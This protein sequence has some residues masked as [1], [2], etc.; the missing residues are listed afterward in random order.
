M[1]NLKF[2][3]LLT[4]LSAFLFSHSEAQLVKTGA[5][6]LF[7]KHL[8]LIKGKRVGLVVN[9]TAVLADGRHL[10]DVVHEQED[11]TLAALFGP[12]HSVRGDTTGAVVDAVDVKTGVPVYSLYGRTYKSKVFHDLLWYPPS[13]LL[14]T[15]VLHPRPE[16]L[17]RIDVLIFDIQDIGARFYTYISTLGYVMEAAA[18]RGI[19]IIVLDRP[20][21]IR[22]VYV[23]G[24]VRDDTLKSNVA[25]APITIGH[26]MTV[27]EIARMYNG[28]RWL[29]GGV[30]ADLTVIEMEGW[31]R[32]MWYD[33]TGLDWIAPSPN[34]L[35][36]ET[37]AV[38][39]GMCLFEGAN[40][41]EGRGTDK[42]FEYIG[43]PWA[44]GKRIAKELN[45]LRIKG[46]QF[47]PIDFVPT[48]R[49]GNLSPPKYKG[50]QC[51]GVFVEVTDRNAFESVKTGI[52]MLWVFR[53]LHPEQFKWRVPG[54]DR[55]SGTPS[56]RIMLDAGILPERIF[57]TWEKE[58]AGFREIR[59]KYLLYE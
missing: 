24:P 10:A 11:V 37:A 40:V 34:M 44:D 26:G 45:S 8:D 2:M 36:L 12:E 42:P 5:D 55:L 58:I 23:D 17:E 6:L 56:V 39:P 14:R 51:E 16:V 18:G 30:Q 1:K 54:I 29:Q 7:S 19:P 15:L 52:Y 38:Y 41:S 59:S 28:E 35:T 32:T 20:N 13:V 22:G 27:G 47:R 48:M 3:L 25:Y 9:H 33:E 4:V 31:K 49:A 53:K 21:P 43:A 46:V 50:K 57:R